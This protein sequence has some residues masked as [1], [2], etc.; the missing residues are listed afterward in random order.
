MDY[1]LI[2]ISDLLPCC[3]YFLSLRVDYFASAAAPASRRARATEYSVMPAATE[4]FSD[5]V[6][7]DMGVWRCADYAPMG[8]AGNDGNL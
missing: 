7:R 5:G 8:F 3:A 1:P 2:C 4:A 6:M